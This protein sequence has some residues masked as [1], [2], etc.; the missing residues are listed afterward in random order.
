MN[1]S[2]EIPLDP[3]RRLKARSRPAR[4]AG[5]VAASRQRS[6][7]PARLGRCRG[8]L[9]W[10][11]AVPA[12]GSQMRGAGCRYGPLFP[13]RDFVPPPSCRRTP[14]SLTVSQER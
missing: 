4:M 7:R 10:R 9:S 2:R 5:A 13:P 12:L 3:G 6:P 14:W 1:C 11:R 8:Q